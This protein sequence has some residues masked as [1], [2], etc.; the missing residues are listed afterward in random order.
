MIGVLPWCWPAVEVF[1]AMST[2]WRRAG[3]DGVTVGLDYAA[4]PATLWAMGRRL[5]PSARSSLFADLQIM[6]YA[7]LEGLTHGH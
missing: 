2:Q 5:L 4:L 3:M 7:A 1:L 6:E